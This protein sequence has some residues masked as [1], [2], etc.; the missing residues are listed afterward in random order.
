[1]TADIAALVREGILLALLLAAPVLVAALLAGVFTGLV[2]AVTQVQEPAVGLLPRVAAVGAAIAL[3][4]P[5]VAH[6]LVAFVDR[7]W[8]LIAAAGTTPSGG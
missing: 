2:A 3:F 1:V 4:G 8:P 5:S 7:I 6:Q